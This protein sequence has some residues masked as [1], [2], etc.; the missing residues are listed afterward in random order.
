[1]HALLCQI[2]GLVYQWVYSGRTG[3]MVMQR[4]SGRRNKIGTYEVIHKDT[5]V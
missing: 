2:P 1:M 5:N 4:Q 3:D